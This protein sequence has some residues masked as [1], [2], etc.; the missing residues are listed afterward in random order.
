VSHNAA[1][2]TFRMLHTLI[3]VHGYWNYH[4]ISSLVCFIFY[5]VSEGSRGE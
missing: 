1:I 5:K 2:G 4:R 3:L